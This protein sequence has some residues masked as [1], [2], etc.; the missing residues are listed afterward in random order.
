MKRIDKLAEEYRL[1]TECHCVEEECIHEGAFKVGFELACKII[2]EVVAW[3]AS[4]Y[5]GAAAAI[6]LDSI[7]DFVREL[8]VKPDSDA[9]R[10]TDQKN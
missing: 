2:E 3:N 10:A 9:E 7:R 4:V 8:P 1:K 5:R 6:P